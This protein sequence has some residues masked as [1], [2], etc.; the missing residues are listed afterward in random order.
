M[1]SGV[2]QLCLACGMCCDGT[3]FGFVALRSGEDAVLKASGLDP[4]PR[5]DG[6]WSLPQPCAALRGTACSAYATR[7]AGCRDFNCGLVQA[8]NEGEVTL[9]EALAVVERAHALRE[10]VERA[11]PPGIPAEGKSVM[12]RA[13]RDG[14]LNLEALRDLED[15]LAF[16]FVRRAPG[17]SAPSDQTI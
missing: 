3:L 13:R 7:P 4:K 15:Y 2:S 12:Q 10:S 8:L 6:R 5:K 14:V 11:L 1:N 17:G 16:H 9:E